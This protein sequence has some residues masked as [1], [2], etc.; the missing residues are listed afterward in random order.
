MSTKF[1]VITGGASGFGRAVAACCAAQGWAVAL[2]DRDGERASSEAAAISD[3]HGVEAIAQQVDV[4]QRSEV[5]AAASLVRE[6]FGRCD[7]LWV[8]VGVQHFGSVESTPEDVWSWVL[9]VNVVGAVRTVQAFL[10]LLRSSDHA[11]LA[12]TT[13][14]N[15]L[16]PAARLGVYQA[17]KFALLG[18][19]ET[20]C[21]E[22]APE[23]IEVSVVFPSGMMTR[24]LESSSEARPVGLGS[25]EVSDDDLVAMMAS[26]PMTEADLTTAEAA[27]AVAVDGVLAGE[28]YVI[29]HGDLVEAVAAHHAAIDQALARLAERNEG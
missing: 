20:L 17:S 28:R 9:D 25:G 8:N 4:G 11:H 10:P 18:V 21:M 7:L 6:R 22:L 2:L 26:R 15:V 13:S 19:A 1:A 29:T 14:A 24:H 16:A 5:E 12:F 23:G 27:A 3:E